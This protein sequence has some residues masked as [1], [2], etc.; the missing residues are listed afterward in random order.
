MTK[1]LAKATSVPA[2]EKAFEILDFITKS[3]MP[4]SSATIAKELS[5]ARS[6]TH[7]ILQ[8]LTNKGVL[9][10]DNNHLYSLGSY[11]L[12]W[13]GRFEVEKG[14]VALFHELVAGF[15]VLTPYTVTLSTLDFERGETVFLSSHTGSSAIDFAFRRGVRVPAVFSATGKAI[16]SQ[17]SFDKVMAMYDEF[18]M[19]ITERGV[20]NFEGLS[21]EFDGIRKTRLSLDDGQLRLGMTCMGTYIQSQDGVRLGI[22]VSLSDSEYHEYKDVIGQALIDLVLQIERGLGFH[23]G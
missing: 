13:A 9:Y 10:R 8:A 19:P 15:E 11:L 6:T 17:C 16:L 23:D 4:V 12:Y 2:L 5:L 22:A 7:N 3:P 18:P 21:A 14:V 1:K 20:S